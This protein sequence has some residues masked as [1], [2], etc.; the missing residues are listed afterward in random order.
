MR[1]RHGLRKL[2][3]TSSGGQRDMVP[4]LAGAAVAAGVAGLFMETHPRPDAALSD[5]PNSVPLHHM[6]ALL[7]T[8][9]ELDQATK[10]HGFLENHFSA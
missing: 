6:P 2:N 8:L 7:E 3:R 4:V 5:G 1:H 10:K 9:L